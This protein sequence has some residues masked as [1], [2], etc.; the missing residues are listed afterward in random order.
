MQKSRSLRASVVGSAAALTA[1]N[2]AR[3]AL[4]IAAREEML[5]MGF[6][7]FI[8]IRA[9]SCQPGSIL[10]C[11]GLEFT[12]EGDV[13]LNSE[14]GSGLVGSKQLGAYPPLEGAD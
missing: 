3:V 13:P 2:R 4:V 1:N 5:G 14:G 11:A 7:P 8:S 12:T 10:L 9:E 6:F